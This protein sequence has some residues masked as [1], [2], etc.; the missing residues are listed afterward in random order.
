MLCNR[1]KSEMTIPRFLTNT[2]ITSI[3]K[4]KGNKNNLE[5]DRGIFG[6]T[7]IRSILE[8]LV[9]EDIYDMIDNTMSDSN[10]GGRRK[11]NIRDN[12]FVLYSVINE[13][14]RCKKDIDIKFYD[15][16]KCFDTMWSEETMNDLYDVGLKDEK[17]ALLSL[18]NEK[19]NVKVKTPV[20]DT[21]EFQLSRVEMQGTVIAPLKCAVQMDT[22]GG[23][24]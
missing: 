10:V 20:G 13:A 9:Y 16:A 11:R 18:L 6:V 8:K 15:L 12:L 19:C 24:C 22:L 4:N 23:Y 7:K 14:I 17:F 21:E 3:Y 5:N 1:V 2:N